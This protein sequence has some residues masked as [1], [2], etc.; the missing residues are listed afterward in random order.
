M[1][2][3]S[4]GKSCSTL[5]QK[6]QAYTVCPCEQKVTLIL[7][8][9]PKYIIS[10]CWGNDLGFLWL[11]VSMYMCLCV[12]CVYKCVCAYKCVLC[13]YMCVCACVFVHV[14]LHVYAC[15]TCGP[16]CMGTCRHNQVTY[17]S[18]CTL[19]KTEAFHDSHTPALI[20]LGLVGASSRGWGEVA[21]HKPCSPQCPPNWAL[22]FPWWAQI[23]LMEQK[24]MI[25]TKHG[26][27]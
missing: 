9:L 19:N 6:C 1:R 15:A 25:A 26:L 5:S 11:C 7:L 22:C 24:L 14:C 27:M 10:N 4:L 18:I 8:I 12:F 20:L 21:W 23:L 17:Q 16:I 2:G 3:W 13:M